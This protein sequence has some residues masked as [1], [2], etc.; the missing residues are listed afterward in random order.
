MKFSELLTDPATGKLAESKIWVNIAKACMV[1]AFIYNVWKDTDTEWLW[2]VFAA[3]LTAHE[4]F[5]RLISWK[6]GGKSEST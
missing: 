2:L 3:I 4:S 1:W 5:S 6:F